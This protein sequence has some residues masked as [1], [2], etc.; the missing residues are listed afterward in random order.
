MGIAAGLFQGN[1]KNTLDW[2]IRPSDEQY[3]QQQERWNDLAAH[4]IEDLNDRSDYPIN[5]W[6]QGSYKFG[7]QV[8]PAGKGQEFDIDLGIYF[9]WDGNP[10]DGDY[11][12]IDL[13]GFVRDSLLEYA[14]D[15]ENEAEQVA[16]SKARCERIHFD[17][18]F[19]IDVPCYHLDPTA[20]VRHLATE[21]DEWETSDPKA[22]YR[23]WKDSFENGNL[24]R[25]R[26]LVRYLKMWAALKFN[27]GDGPSSILLTVLVGEAWDELD[28]E[29]ISGDDE[30]LV[31][32]V[33][34]VVE[35]LQRNPVVP[36]PVD[37]P[38]N[39]NRLDRAKSDKFVDKV[40]DLLAIGE[41]ALAA[42][43]KTLAA[44]IWGEAFGHFFPL[45]E[46]D[47]EMAILEKAG[48]ALVPV[49]FDPRVAIEARPTRDGARTFHGVNEIGPIPKNCDITFTLMNEHELPAGA[50]LRWVARNQ[51][52]EAEDVNDLGH[53]WG[54]Q[55]EVG[56]QSAYR[57]THYM[58]VSVR[59]D[60]RIIGRRRIPVKITGLAL[61]VRNPPRPNWTKLRGRR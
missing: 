42:P 44:E 31:A 54:D 15:D 23:W 10:Q 14:A 1:S 9:R 58:D 40:E 50:T 5:S 33:S 56:E 34:V 17:A 6:L 4:L 12:P 61:P 29:A 46:E 7:T 18:D 27:E 36:N 37:R 30:Y 52:D 13:K 53:E 57:G 11:D 2:R 25:L 41:R 16:D 21:S 49:L 24:P 32:I 38:E 28:H 55:R 20:D 60:D 8:R 35:R 59:L 48:G 47:E 51:G 22:I 19:H 3:E 45:P 26:R 39:M 43:T